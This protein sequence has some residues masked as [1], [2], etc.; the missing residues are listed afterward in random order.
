[1]TILTY[2][3]AFFVIIYEERRKKI[4]KGHALL[5]GL[6]GRSVG[7]GVP[8][9]IT[10]AQGAYPGTTNERGAYCIYVNET[11]NC[12][13]ELPSFLGARHPINS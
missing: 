13:F 8:I 9:Q 10:C 5:V 1:M 6:N 12:S 7:H 3:F 2:S 11:G 4:A